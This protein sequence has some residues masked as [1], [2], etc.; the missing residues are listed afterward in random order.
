MVVSTASLWG[1][2]KLDSPGCL[3]GGKD[4]TLFSESENDRCQG[5]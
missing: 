2:A 5:L 4:E 1:V 3:G